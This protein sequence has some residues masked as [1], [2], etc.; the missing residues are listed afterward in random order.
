MEC[1]ACT[2]NCPAR[3]RLVQR[4][5]VGKFHLRNH[6]AAKQALEKAKAEAAAKAATV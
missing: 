4:F 6:M 3:I 5:R 2:F 1:G